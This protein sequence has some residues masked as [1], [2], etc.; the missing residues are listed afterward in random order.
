MLFTAL[1][2]GVQ[3]YREHLQTCNFPVY[4]DL[5]H[6]GNMR[7]TGYLVVHYK[8]GEGFYDWHNDHCVAEQGTFRDTRWSHRVV[9][10]QD[11]S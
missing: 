10:Y 3:K 7:D 6:L 9:W 4:P 8:A 2:Q 5:M 11:G 1:A